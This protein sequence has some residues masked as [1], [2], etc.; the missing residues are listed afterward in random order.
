M[1]ATRAAQ[2]SRR[3]AL[4]VLSNL[5]LASTAWKQSDTLLMDGLWWITAARAA[6]AS[7]RL[8]LPVSPLTES[9]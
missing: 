6:Q 2:A 7:R 3:L 4:P 9:P 1:A 5:C 8:A